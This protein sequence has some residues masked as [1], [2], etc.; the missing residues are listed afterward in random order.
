MT[1]NWKMGVLGA[2]LALFVVALLGA[3][4]AFSTPGHRGCEG[5]GKGGRLD[6]L[7][8]KLADLPLDTETRAA[9]AQ[10]LERAR[11]E[12]EARHE[13]L[14]EARHNL[15]ALLEQETPVVEQVMAQAEALGALE[16]EAH[17]SKLRTM[18]ELRA[19]LGAEQWEALRSSLHEHRGER[20]E[21]S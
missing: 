14:R 5:H 11:S 19:L 9:A 3:G 6:R 1:G 13:D 18:L 8:A 15:Y 21:K 12:R 7:E 10:V 17:K 2:V 16:T 4:T 20:M